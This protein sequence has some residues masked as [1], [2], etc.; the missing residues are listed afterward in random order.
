MNVRI[1]IRYKLILPKGCLRE[2]R[3][4]QR[5]NECLFGYGE[6]STRPDLSARGSGVTSNLGPPQGVE[7]G[8][9]LIKTLLLGPCADVVVSVAARRST[10]I[11]G[12]APPTQ[13]IRCRSRYGL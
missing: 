13:K 3:L 1:M 5:Q 7:N 6:V 4:L 8:P 11:G 9:P 2:T 12:G 10:L